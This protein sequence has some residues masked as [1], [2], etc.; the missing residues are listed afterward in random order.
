MKIEERIKRLLND[1]DMKSP[2]VTVLMSVYN[3]EEYLREAIESILNQT[4]EDFEFLIINDGS[5][6]SSR[7]IVLSY[8]DPRAKLIDNEVN[9][10]LTRSLNRGL[11]LARGEYIA[12]MDADDVSLAERLEKQVSYLETRPEIGVLGTWVKYIDGY[13]RSIK[14]MHPPMGPDLIKWSLLFGNRLV[15]SSVMIQSAILEQVGTYSNEMIVAQDY[16]LWVRVSFETQ[17]QLA[18]LHEELH[19]L[20]RDI[21]S[22]MTRHDHVVEQEATGIMQMAISTMLGEKVPVEVIVSLRQMCRGISVDPQYIRQIGKLIKQLY[23]VYSKTVCPSEARAVAQ[24][25]ARLARNISLTQALAI[26]IEA[27]KLDPLKDRK[28]ISTLMK[29][30]LGERVMNQLRKVKR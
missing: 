2:K 25:A 14:E 29:L 22:M 1:I 15:H 30:V 10:G 5:T 23:Q 27:V 21:R 18:I 24:D 28:I 12:R 6:D 8:R 4:F 9:I 19:L 26:F 16:D 17:F 20:R 3:G 7:D 13:G 11:E